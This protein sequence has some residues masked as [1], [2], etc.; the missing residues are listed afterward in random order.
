MERKRL[1][2]GIDVD[3][4][5]GD[6]LTRAYD[7]CRSFCGKPVA[8]AVQTSWGFESIG[9]TDDEVTELWK[10]IDS[11]EDWWLGHKALPG[12]TFLRRMANEHELYFI[13]SRQQGAGWPIE[14]QTAAWLEDTFGI[15]LPCVIV[16]HRKGPIASALKLDYF[17]DDRDKNCYEV[18]K[19]I[20]MDKVFI[21]RTTYNSNANDVQQVVD[22]D[23]FFDKIGAISGR[24]NEARWWQVAN[25]PDTS[26]PAN[27]A[28]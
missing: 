5:C 25:G 20:G 19:A 18:G 26:L 3:G 9:I 10:R 23:D 17:V 15:E 6:F 24:G 11:T 16:S 21:V 8:G 14:K 4:V 13:T 1:K 27:A 28:G 2:I 12:T 7:I 22:L